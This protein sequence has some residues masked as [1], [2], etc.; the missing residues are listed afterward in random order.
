MADFKLDF[1]DSEFLSKIDKDIAAMEALETQSKETGAAIETAMDQGAAAAGDF[2]KSLEKSERQL[3]ANAK[4]VQDNSKSLT[5]WRSFLR[6]AA[7][8]T[9][10]MGKS[11]AE[12]KE[13]L[14]QT[15]ER[16]SSVTQ[17]VEG[18]TKATRI[19]N[20][21]L[22]ASPIF[23]LV[24]IIAAVLTY[25]S[26]FQKGMDL[27]ARVTSA[28]SAALDAAVKSVA[29]FGK[30]IVS[31][32]SGN[33]SQGFAEI[34]EAV[35]GVG[36]AMVDAATQAYNLEQSLQSLRD[37]QTKSRLE[38][39]QQ[40][41][42]IEQL[43]A[44]GEDETATNRQRIKANQEALA[45]SNEYYKRE[46]EFA[47]ERA[48]L[49]A[50]EFGLSKK[51]NEDIE[52]FQDAIIARE[53]L[54]AEQKRNTFEI[55]KSIRDARKNAA[56]EEKKRRDDE[57]K[58]LLEIEKL[59]IE[60]LRDGLEKEIAQENFRFKE[61]KKKLDEANI[62]TEQAQEQHGKNI[63][64]IRL[65]Y[66][67]AQLALQNAALEAEKESLANGLAELE[68]LDADSAEERIRIAKEAKVI[69]DQFAEI[70]A[71]NFE[72]TQ[73]N[74]RK[75]FFARARSADEIQ[76][77]EKRLADEKEK[78]DLQQQAAQLQRILDFDKT[79][80]ETERLLLEK[81]I[82]NLQEAI[83]QVGQN[84]E[85][86]KP[87]T[88]QSLLGF[89]DEE[90]AALEDGVSRIIDSINQVL[91][92]RIEA[93]RKERELADERVKLA[94]ETVEKEKEQQENGNANKLALAQKNLADEKAARDKALKEEQDAVRAKNALETLQQ[95]TSLI[96]AS[97]NIFQ[98][99]SG[100]PFVG[101]P[102][103]IALIATMFTAFAAAK[104]NATK[105]SKT[106]LRK[107]GKLSGPDHESGGIDILIGGKPS[108]YEAEG[109]EWVINRRASNEHDRFLHRLNSGKFRGVDL[110]RAVSYYFAAAKPDAGVLH[111][112]AMLANDASK[113]MDAVTSD[114]VTRKQFEALQ[115][116]LIDTVKNRPH[117][118]P[119]KSGYKQ[120]IIGDHFR[121]TRNV[122]PQD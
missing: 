62:D 6:G 32:F 27:V 7:D 34:K 87:F 38:A 16:L 43:K 109:D 76:E 100:I 102:L 3:Q 88:L 107:G 15:R 61:L 25:L 104:I 85:G 56:E 66:Y 117:F 8:E 30:G 17:N 26:K 95:T 44:A 81:R 2:D 36:Q 14:N 63:Q 53:E 73:L 89:S 80:T 77:F 65:K 92:A 52:K 10:V 120:I 90:F 59:R 5:I 108:Q 118:A 74:L 4:A 103:A 55:E 67:L 18:S 9:Q 116:E 96:T 11:V 93:A 64:Q 121:E 33:F 72:A 106:P 42:A 49:A 69:Q 101:V 23:L 75:A 58:R 98:S 86:K 82:A 37:A 122:Q 110:D 99:L 50:Q 45:V 46:L 41:A 84:E 111:S 78:F 13:Q 29:S 35:T 28:A 21:V 20:L 94:E 79:L 51:N 48:R 68:K 71:A 31:I 112:R 119:W 1:D 19:F 91:D 83:A 60:A 54:L 22:K 113:K 24:G 105:A 57:A 40:K 39:F 115:R 97:A 47:T 114:H 70:N 12:W